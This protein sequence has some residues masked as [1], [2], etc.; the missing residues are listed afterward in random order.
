MLYIH[1]AIISE[2]THVCTYILHTH[3]HLSVQSIEESIVFGLETRALI[4]ERSL[5]DVHYQSLLALKY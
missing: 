2:H 5:P 4:S 3:T 1:L